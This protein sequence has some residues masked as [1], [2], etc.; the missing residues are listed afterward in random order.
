LHPATTPGL[1][2]LACAPKS[3]P[4]REGAIRHVQVNAKDD[5]PGEGGGG[6]YDR[7]GRSAGAS[8]PDRP[9]EIE[10]SWLSGLPIDLAAYEIITRSSVHRKKDETKL[11]QLSYPIHSFPSNINLSFF[12]SVPPLVYCLRTLPSLPFFLTTNSRPSRG[13]RSRSPRRAGRA[14]PRIN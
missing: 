5:Q 12:S 14:R 6:G 4:S 1:A 2:R 13:Q 7:K 10:M 3:R 8:S 11:R 9:V